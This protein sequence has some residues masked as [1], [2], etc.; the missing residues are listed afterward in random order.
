MKWFVCLWL[1]ISAVLLA[2]NMP[3]PIWNLPPT[4]GLENPESAYFDGGHDV[5]FVSNVAGL[6]PTKKDG[7]GWISKV[8]VAGK[9]LEKQWI[10]GLNAPK[11]LRAAGNTLWVTDIDTLVSIDIE[12]RQILDKILFPGAQFLNDIAIS[13]QGDVYISDMVANKIYLLHDKKVTVFAAGEQLECPNGLLLRQDK[14]V[15]ASF[16]L[17][18]QMGRLYQ[19]D[20]RSKAKSL[21]T[22]K[23]L[24]RL[25]GLEVDS[26]G[27]YLV[28]SWESVDSK[29]GR[30]YR[31]TPSGKI[32]TLFANVTSPADIGLVPK[33]NLLLV[34]LMLENKVLAFTLPKIR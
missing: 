4:S 26:E 32:T 8:S 23:P 18:A 21:I 25:D 20:L 31:I 29:A 1:S 19:L 11:G 14:L 9:V 12:K 16:G 15:V 33:E 13:E 24:G 22:E 17:G 5:I 3:T 7:R 28:S 10:S 27:N 30:V 6:P 2:Q 34:P